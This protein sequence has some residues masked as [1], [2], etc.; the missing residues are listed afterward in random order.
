MRVCAIV[1]RSPTLWPPVEKCKLNETRRSYA[2]AFTN[3][4]NTF[5]PHRLRRRRRRR[6]Q[7][8]R[9]LRA[10]DNVHKYI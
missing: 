9:I 8:T 1:S 2:H 3:R 4:L 7:W 10:Q 6:R 5:F